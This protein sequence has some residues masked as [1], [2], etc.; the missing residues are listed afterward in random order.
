MGNL[1]LTLTVRD[2]STSLTPCSSTDRGLRWVPPGGV[3]ID[4]SWGRTGE[5]GEG[6]LRSEGSSV[7]LMPQESRSRVRPPAPTALE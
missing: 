3:Q 6:G 2:I 5:T 7:L 1:S 4:G